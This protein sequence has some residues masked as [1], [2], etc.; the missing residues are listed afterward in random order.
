[1]GTREQPAQSEM[2][3][4]SAISLVLCDKAR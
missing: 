4:M 3:A 1:M 2:S